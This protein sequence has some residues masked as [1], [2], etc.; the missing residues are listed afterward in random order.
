MAHQG[1]FVTIR[2]NVKHLV[3]VHPSCFLSRLFVVT[4]GRAVPQLHPA[5]I[6][7][8]SCFPQP[9]GPP[10]GMSSLVGRQEEQRHPG[11]C[12]F[13]LSLLSPCLVWGKLGDPVCAAVKMGVMCEPFWHPRVCWSIYWSCQHLSSLD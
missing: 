2:R 6:Y 9:R 7:A 11:I 1:P 4:F 3:L 13:R 8:L 5:L 10:Y 12:G